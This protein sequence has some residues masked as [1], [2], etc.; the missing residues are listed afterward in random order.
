MIRFWICAFSLVIAFLPTRALAIDITEIRT[1]LGLKV[2]L[3]EDHTLPIITLSFAFRGGATQDA[4]GKSG[5]MNLMASLLDEGAGPYSGEEFQDRLEDIAARMSFSTTR[6][7]FYGSMRT[8]TGNADEAF[9]LLQLALYEPRFD[10]KPL[11][12]IRDQLLSRIRSAQNNPNSLASK[13]MRDMIY[14]EDHPYRRTSRGTEQTVSS[15]VA[16][17]L[18][19]IKDKTMARDNLIISIV[20]DITE[21]EVKRRLDGLFKDLPEK[22]DLTDVARVE[23]QLGKTKVI[24]VNRPQTRFS[25]IGKG[26]ARDDPDYIAAYLVN[27][28]LGGSGLTSRLSTEVREKRGLAYNISTGLSNYASASIFAGSVATRA[29]FANET[30]EVLKSELKRMADEGP[31]AEEL[32]LAKSYTIG[33]YALNFDGSWDIAS[34]LT[35]LQANNLPSD[36]IQIRADIINAVTLDQAKAAAKRLL[37]DNKYTLVR[38]GPAPQ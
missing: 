3:V 33:V 18:R 21:A 20:G 32:E 1:D 36:Y 30:L 24:D 35:S 9:D 2:L 12:R 8:L 25:I 7:F 37:G 31:T 19:A 22:A 10:E 29:D 26:V 16:D 6:D 28:I 15:L 34:T 5:S 13:A 11:N 23:P 4:V 17:D 14:P 38:L 27:Q